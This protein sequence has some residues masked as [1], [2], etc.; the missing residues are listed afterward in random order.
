[1]LLTAILLWSLNLTV[2]RYILTNG[3][4]PLAYSAVRYGLA[5]AV[6]VAMTVVVERS[7][8]IAGR[9]N[10]KLI[11]VAI[12]A[13][14][15]NQ[16]CF[17]YALKTTSASTIALILGATPIITAVLGLALGTEKLSSKFWFGGAV[18]FAGVALVAAGASGGLS[19]DFG[20]ILLGLGTAAT[21]GVYSIAIT[22]MMGVVSPS[23]VSA[24][25]LSFAWIPIVLLATPQL[26]EQ[27]WD[28]GW[29]VWALLVFATLGPLVLTNVLW[30]RS[31]HRIG[32]SRATLAANL[33]PFIAAVIALV[34][35]DEPLTAV[36]VAG[37]V[38][39]GAGILLARGIKRAPPPAQLE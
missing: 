3:F 21:W 22:P 23:R 15:A 25:A 30:F 4:L 32:P 29:E 6:F 38:L 35:L 11:G 27:D 39:I 24:V 1:M 20:G 37:G 12:L 19:S 36:Q 28:L 33:Q 16:V 8:R 14:V 13:L 31:L 9:R 34:L 2:T 5:A 26:K 18:S 17:V 7:L 10:Q